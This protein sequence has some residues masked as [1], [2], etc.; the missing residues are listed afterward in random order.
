MR[1]KIY[2]LIERIVEE[3]AEAG[4]NRAHKHTDSPNEETIKQCIHQYI[5]NGFDEYFEFAGEDMSIS[6]LHKEIN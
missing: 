2:Q 1:L 3:G 4:Y 6:S 5:M